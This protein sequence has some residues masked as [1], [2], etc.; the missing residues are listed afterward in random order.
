M[1]GGLRDISGLA[2]IGVEPHP[3]NNHDLPLVQI[4]IIDQAYSHINRQLR[5]GRKIVRRTDRLRTPQLGAW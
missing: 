2:K 4:V 3:P 5:E 1:S